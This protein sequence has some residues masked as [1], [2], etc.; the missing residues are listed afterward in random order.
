MRNYKY[1]WLI[2]PLQDLDSYIERQMFGCKTIYLYG[3]LVLVLADK[4]EPWRGLLFPVERS[5]QASVIKE[6]SELKP[7][8]VLGKWLY[9]PE[10]SENF[11]SLGAS[12]IE[13]IRHQD[14]RFGTEPEPKKSKSKKARRRS[15]S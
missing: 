4:E 11:E 14:H 12:V 7:H 5:Q 15:R 2:E 6:Y 10:D 8:G 9:L 1:D 3:K 13:R